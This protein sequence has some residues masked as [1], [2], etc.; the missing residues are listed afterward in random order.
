MPRSASLLQRA[1][2]G[3]RKFVSEGPYVRDSTQRFGQRFLCFYCPHVSQTEG[4]RTRHILRTETCHQAYV[5]Q[6]KAGLQSK[7]QDDPRI[8][9]VPE[10]ELDEPS[11]PKPSREANPPPPVSPPVFPP[12]ALPPALSLG[13][14]G[15]TL[16]YDA[17][18]QVF[19]ERFPDPR[20]GAP[21]NDA[22]VAPLDLQSYMA[23]SGNL[24][25]P[26]HFDTAELLMTTG[27]TNGGRDAHLKS[28]LVSGPL[29]QRTKYLRIRTVSGPNSMGKQ[30]EY[31]GRHR[32]TA[33]RAWMEV[34]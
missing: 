22:V 26:D 14:H 20:A 4:G 15:V 29:V 30:P 28:R 12:P 3:Q 18:R 31:D 6:L 11:P 17:K 27:L 19:V 9:R 16:E 5:G 8:T 33:S 1:L 13:T 23:N 2:R 24:G 34:I 32:Q 10:P 25:N 7:A 21:I